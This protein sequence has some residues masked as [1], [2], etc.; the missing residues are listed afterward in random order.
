MSYELTSNAAHRGMISSVKGGQRMTFT[1]NVVHVEPGSELDR[2]LD[3]AGESEVELE[4][5][6]IRY[7]LERISDEVIKDI[8]TTY[9]PDV[10]QA[11]M[12][13]AAGTWSDVNIEQLKADLY[14]AREEG[15]R[16]PDR[17]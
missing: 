17:P 10:A 12:H 16:P 5:G 1:P 4:R 7:R 14:R 6:G 11:G 2:V 15:T 3:T 9:D 8:W 13:A